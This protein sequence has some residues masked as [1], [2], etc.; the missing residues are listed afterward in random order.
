MAEKSK[1]SESNQFANW[2][3]LAELPVP[4]PSENFTARVMEK[5]PQG[6]PKAWTGF[7]VYLSMPRTWGLSP[8]RA[9]T[10]RATRAECAFYIYMAAFGLLVLS[11]ALMLGLRGFPDTI[12]VWTWLASQPVICL[13]LSVMLAAIGWLVSRGGRTGLKIARLA[14]WG[15]TVLT[16]INAI[17]AVLEFGR[18]IWFRPFIPLALASVILGAFLALALRTTDNHDNHVVEA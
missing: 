16:I 18:V 14:V 10:G 7:W 13:V 11:L 1:T 2:Q 12:P 17:P 6:R 9:L 3:S 4:E 15:F 5:T 8:A